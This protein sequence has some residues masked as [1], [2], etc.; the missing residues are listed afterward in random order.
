MKIQ[1]R[2]FNLT[3]AL[4]M[5]VGI[6]A[7]CAEYPTDTTAPVDSTSTPFE[8]EPTTETSGV[9]DST[10]E[11]IK[12]PA[13]DSYVI[14]AENG[15]L[16][17]TITRSEGLKSS[18]PIIKKQ[19]YVASL[20]QDFLG[21]SATLDTDWKRKEDSESFE[22]IVGPTDHEE[23]AAVYGTL[24][25]G[26]WL[27]Q[28]VGNKILVLGHTEETLELASKHLYNVLK[29]GR[30]NADKTITFTPDDVYARGSAN[31]QLSNLPS[32]IGGA[33]LTYCDAGF[34][35]SVR[36]C[37]EI[38]VKQTK[39]TE[40]DAYIKRLEANGYAVYND[41]EV[42]R[43]KFV[44]LNSD[45]YTVNAGY[46]NNEGAARIMIEPLAPA[47]SLGGEYKKVTT[48][49]II[50]LGTEPKRG[51]AGRNNQLSM[52]IRL[53]DG[54]FIVVDGGEDS[55]SLGGTKDS[56]TNPKCY[57]NVDSFINL[58]K[59]QS[60]GYTDTP[61]VAAWFLTHDHGDHAH[62]L[63]FDYDRMKAAGIK[64]EN[65]YASANS[66]ALLDQSGV[67]G[68]I[69]NSLFSKVPAA[70]GA[71]MHRVHPGQVITYA[72]CEIDILY[73]LEAWVDGD[74]AITP[75]AGGYNHS[76]VI[77]KTTVTDS[78]SKKTMSVFNTGDGSGQAMQLAMQIFGE[79]EI[80]SD[81]AVATHH[82]SGSGDDS[83]IVKTVKAMAPQIV[84]FPR[85]ATGLDASRFTDRK[86]NSELIATSKEAFYAGLC[87]SYTIIPVPYE[88]GK[89]QI[90]SSTRLK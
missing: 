72:N 41:N 73:T 10:E 81:I 32:Y 90:S 29:K 70:F 38:I 87:E 44:T 67:S 25:Y 74:P 15:V 33:F 77:F 3:L 60:K 11:P 4:L 12:P 13:N 5:C 42:N 17:V 68:G 18:S 83:M 47:Y 57:D 80:K 64:V 46:Y 52:V 55:T 34:A 21:A 24:S 20:L 65:I 71:N 78:A 30:N 66:K 59:E 14:K 79:E 63:T 45:G 48:S 28:A 56:D 69:Y 9:A 19:Q 7:S 37:D 8:S 51:D 26:D 43:S 54:R 31:A 75:Q 36:E 22:I 35:D 58:L 88:Y 39:R 76:S 16:N 2:V 6:F 49:N 62:L 53:E 85:G 23:V 84:L 82:G 50:L 1:V 40:F 27:V 89:T 86:S 61:T